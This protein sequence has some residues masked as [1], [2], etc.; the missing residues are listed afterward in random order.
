MIYE[1]VKNLIDMLSKRDTRCLSR[2]IVRS[3]ELLHVP[4]RISHGKKKV[5]LSFLFSLRQ[6]SY[7]QYVNWIMCEDIN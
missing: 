2:E 3:C 7:R 1:V 5:E 6:I 4:L